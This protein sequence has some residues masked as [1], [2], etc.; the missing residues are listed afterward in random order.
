MPDPN[1]TLPSPPPV[2]NPTA[3]KPPGPPTPSKKAIGRSFSYPF[4]ALEEAVG[5]ARKFY[6]EER[7]MAAPV[8]AAIRHF[9][10]SESSSGGRQTISALLQFGLL[11]D[12]GRSEDRLVK[13][14]DRALT[15][16]LAE[17]N[18]PERAAAL[19]ECARMPKV[20][21]ELLN[22]WVDDLPS[23]SSLS[24]FLLKTKDLNPNNVNSF[25]KNFRRTLAYAGA[26]PRSSHPQDLAPLDREEDVEV[27]VEVGD[28]VQWESGGV[29]QF[30]T[31][32]KVVAKQE[33]EGRWWAQIEGSATGVLVDELTVISKQA[34]PLPP[35]TP[36]VFTLQPQ[37][38]TETGSGMTTALVAG[39]EE[40]SRGRLSKETNYRLLITGEMGSKEIARLIRLLEAQ[41]QVLDEDSA[42]EFA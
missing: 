31:P 14:T 15:I 9:G 25:I 3:P 21:A 23:D 30:S 16:I 1:F 12:E 6:Q 26:G 17:P 11:E 33:H 8:A 41:K 19:R 40:W 18:S 39:E 7:K 10:Y 32:R 34:S 42:D 27:A 29:L 22:K 28:C 38:P 20:Y 36:P 4:I 35:V 5:V 24:Y 2:S 37:T 13:L